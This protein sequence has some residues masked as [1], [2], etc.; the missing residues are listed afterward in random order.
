MKNEIVKL[1]LMLFLFCAIAAGILAFS[2]GVTHDIILETEELASSG[3]DVANAVIPG[4]VGFEV[5]DNSII[6]KISSENEKF[7]D[8]KA[9]IDESGAQVGYA[10]RTFSTIVGYGGDIEL[11]V[12]ISA[13]GE[14]AGVK[15]LS[16]K[17]TPGLGTNVEKSDFQAQFIGKT[18]DTELVVVKLPPSSDNEVSSLAGATFSSVS[19]NS[20]VN[21]AMSIYNEYIK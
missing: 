17:E 11:F 9:V 6:E 10:V 2:N 3:P 13:D 4:A 14:V 7:V 12:G 20:A 21:N 1:G 5:L 8:A 19:F 15:V 18:V 16:L